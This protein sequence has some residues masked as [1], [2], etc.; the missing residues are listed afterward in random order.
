MDERERLAQQR[1]IAEE[2]GLLQEQM[3]GTRMAGRVSAWLLMCDP[4]SQS[5]TQ[6]AEALGVSK[7]AVSGALRFLLQ[8]GSAERVSVPGARGDWY[9]AASSKLDRVLRVGQVRAARLLLERA[10]TTV[11]DKD[12]TRQNYAIMR[13]AHDFFVFLEGELP[14]LQARWQRQRAGRRAAEA[15]SND[16][17]ATTRSSGG[18]P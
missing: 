13:D 14:G 16:D 12:Q 3:G 8:A 15:A 1:Q 4:P 11:A 9:E 2:L 7:A 17:R 18:A 5:L 6:I 10:L